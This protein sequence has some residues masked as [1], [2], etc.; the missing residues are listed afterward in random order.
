MREINNV[1]CKALGKFSIPTN[2]SILCINMFTIYMHM[3]KQ[4]HTDMFKQFILFRKQ[5]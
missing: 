5:F 4:M 3:H 1:Y 2:I